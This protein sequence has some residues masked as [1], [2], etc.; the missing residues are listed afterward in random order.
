MHR[1]KDVYLPSPW[2]QLL[3]EQITIHRRYHYIQ[4]IVYLVIIY[5]LDGN[6]SGGYRYPPIE[7]LGPDEYAAV[8]L[9]NVMSLSTY[10]FSKSATILSTAASGTLP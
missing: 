8:G 1:L 2:A 4:W 7:Q 9:K 5:P 10:C 6:L 3:K